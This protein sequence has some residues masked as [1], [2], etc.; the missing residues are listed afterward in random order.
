M[1]IC[2]YTYILLH[3]YPPV[4]MGPMVVGLVGALVS[5]LARATTSRATEGRATTRA[6]T[7]ALPPTTRE[8]SAALAKLSQVCETY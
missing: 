2:R 5:P 7:A 6:L 4:A 8:G 1:K 3:L